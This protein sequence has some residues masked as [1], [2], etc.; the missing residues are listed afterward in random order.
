VL[1][2]EERWSISTQDHERLGL[3]PGVRRSSDQS[4]NVVVGLAPLLVQHV[5]QAGA[6]MLSDLRAGLSGMW[7]QL[8]KGDADHF[9]DLRIATRFCVERGQ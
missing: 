3:W 6:E 1:K 5:G 9:V 2:C 8:D 7:E 4:S